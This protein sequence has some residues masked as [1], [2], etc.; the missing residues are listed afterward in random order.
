MKTEQELKALFGKNIKIRREDRKWS[1]ETLGEKAGVGRNTISDIESGQ[2]FVGAKTLLNLALALETQVYELF[3]PDN[4]QP[5]NAYEILTKCSFAVKEA[6]ET[7]F[8]E[9]RKNIKNN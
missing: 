8:D 6:L 4:V 5:D 2:D 7:T 9:I 1:Q 3:K